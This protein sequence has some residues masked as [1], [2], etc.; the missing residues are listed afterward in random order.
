MI[1]YPAERKTG[2]SGLQ[3]IFTTGAPISI[4]LQAIVFFFQDDIDNT[5]NRIRA[6]HSGR[7]TLENFN[8][9]DAARSERVQVKRFARQAIV[10]HAPAIDQ[11]Q[12]VAGRQAP[13][14]DAGCAIATVTN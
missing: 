13:E 5:R 8:A 11:Y 14:R 9:V 3:V 7:A 6:I 4:H 12:S 10:S 1:K 2:G